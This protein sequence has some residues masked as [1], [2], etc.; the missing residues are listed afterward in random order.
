MDMWLASHAVMI[1]QLTSTG[2]DTMMRML[3]CHDDEPATRDTLYHAYLKSSIRAF[4]PWSH[5][6]TASAVAPPNDDIRTRPMMINYIPKPGQNAK[7][8]VLA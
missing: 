3:E 8:K 6:H 7:R 5:A 2:Q 4:L 1:G